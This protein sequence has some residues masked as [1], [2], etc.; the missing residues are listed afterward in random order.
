VTPARVE[1]CGTAS[2]AKATKAGQA[3]SR[4]KML[5]KMEPIS[6]MVDSD[7]LPFYLP[8][9]QKELSPPIVA[10]ESASVGYDERVILSR[11]SLN[12]SNDDR[13]GLLGS[14]GNGKSTFA[15]LVG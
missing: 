2:R 4:L 3:Q 1:N 7:V 6:A 13:I 14:N 12:I 5:A 10:M 15:K 9:P 8:S 11:L